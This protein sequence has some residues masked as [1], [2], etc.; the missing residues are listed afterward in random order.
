MVTL[1]HTFATGAALLVAIVNADAGAIVLAMVD[2][3]AGVLHV[4]TAMVYT[5]VGVLVALAEPAGTLTGIIVDPADP[6][7]V[8]ILGIT[9]LIPN[10]Y[11]RRPLLLICN[12]IPP[13]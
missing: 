5:N 1:G 7:L 8:V 13:G 3:H 12:A 4:T 11:G 10:L 6:I 2:F 9:T